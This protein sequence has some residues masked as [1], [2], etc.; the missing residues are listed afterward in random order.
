MMAPFSSLSQTPGAVLDETPLAVL[1]ASGAAID[2]WPL[3]CRP[4]AIAVEMGGRAGEMS[5]F[6]PCF[7]FGSH[8]L[9]PA[10][11]VAL[12]VS[13]K[14][15]SLALTSALSFAHLKFFFQI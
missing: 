9:K 11:L 3:L 5:G 2:G 12:I 14:N 4:G 6:A 1:V 8:I 7:F 10:Y 15:C 13:M